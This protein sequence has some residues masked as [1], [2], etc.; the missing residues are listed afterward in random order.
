LASE[1]SFKGEQTVTNKPT[2]ADI[3]RG[4]E[5]IKAREWIDPGDYPVGLWWVC[6]AYMP[7]GKRASDGIADTPGEAMALA[8]INSWA[9]DALEDGDGLD[10]VPLVIPEG[11]RFELTPPATE[12]TV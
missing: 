2:P 10:D 5:L 4:I 9:P 12:K 1:A 6:E 7:D 3:A 11:W 8:W